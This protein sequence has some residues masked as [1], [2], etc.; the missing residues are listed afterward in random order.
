MAEITADARPGGLSGS[1]FI[2]AD[3]DLIS[4]LTADDDDRSAA[5]A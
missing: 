3:E 2:A 1:G 4:V 5:W